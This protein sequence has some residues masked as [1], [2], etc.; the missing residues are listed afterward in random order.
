VALI[1]AVIAGVRLD[2]QT[3]PLDDLLT[4]RRPW[5]DMSLTEIV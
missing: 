4:D 1:V 3:L 2:P 5:R